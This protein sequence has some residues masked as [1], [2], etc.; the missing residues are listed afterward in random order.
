[1]EK[2]FD[3][4]PYILMELLNQMEKEGKLKCCEDLIGII[5]KLVKKLPTDPENLDTL[6]S[7]YQRRGLFRSKLGM[8]AKAV[9]DFK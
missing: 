4:E 5:I 3:S 9:K 6:L 2:Y 1:M 8:S 7:L